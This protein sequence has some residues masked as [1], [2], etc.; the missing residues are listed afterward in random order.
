MGE[1]SD[2]ERQAFAYL[3]NEFLWPFDAGWVRH[4]VRDALRRAR[5][6]EA[7]LDRLLAALVEHWR[8]EAPSALPTDVTLTIDPGQETYRDAAGER[9]MS[10]E[11]RPRRRATAVVAW[12]LSSLLLLLAL[13]GVAMPSDDPLRSSDYGIGD[14][15]S[16]CCFGPPLL[17][18]ALLSIW[19]SFRPPASP[20]SLVRE[21]TRLSLD[22]DPS[23]DTD[24]VEVDFGRRDEVVVRD[25]RGRV[26]TFYRSDDHRRT[27]IV[28]IVLETLVRGGRHR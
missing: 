3:E 26:R 22:D 19:R 17:L 2:R 27:R 24:G 14:I 11:A 28:A 25:A 8:K 12:V 18:L 21:G 13:I 9:W 10:L 5:A 4:S 20:H 15:T 1:V 7:A 16:V 23:G 6:D